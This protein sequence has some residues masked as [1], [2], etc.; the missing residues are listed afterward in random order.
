MRTL[1]S[2]NSSDE[3]ELKL[4]P[5]TYAD[6]Y[7]VEPPPREPTAPPKRKILIYTPRVSV[8]PRKMKRDRKRRNK[9][10]PPPASQ[11]PNVIVGPVLKIGRATPSFDKEE[12]EREL[13]S[14]KK[15]QDPQPTRLELPHSFSC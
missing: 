10:P 8:S 7:Y 4:A 13:Q 14:L 5:T 11:D 1:S 3:F 9:K 6:N 15:S 12:E 2:S